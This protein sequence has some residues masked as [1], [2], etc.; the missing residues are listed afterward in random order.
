MARQA[1]C[2]DAIDDETLPGCRRYAIIEHEGVTIGLLG[3]IEDSWLETLSS[4]D[5]RDLQYEDF[6]E[7]ARWWSRRLREDHQCDIVIALTHMRLP[8]DV[9]LGRLG[10]AIGV[11]LVLGG[12]DHFYSTQEALPA[13]SAEAAAA[14]LDD[15]Q[16]APETS[17][18]GP[19]VPGACLVAKSGTD[20]RN[21]TDIRLTVRL[22]APLDEA[23]ET[24]RGGVAA[25]TWEQREVTSALEP[26]AED[27]GLVE[28]LSSSMAA[29][30]GQVLGHIHA[31]LDGRFSSVRGG[32]SN[33]GN[34]VC[35][36]M[37]RTARADCAL[38]NGGTL[39]S[40][41]VHPA[42][43][44]TMA[45]LLKISPYPSEVPTVRVS[46]R[47]I[48]E[49]LENGV[50]KY[51]ES[52]GRF[53][54]VAGIR[55]SFN[56]DA[57][58]MSR[59]DPA[60]VL[61]GHC[62][63]AQAPLNLERRYTLATTD[64]LSL[65]KDGFESI[66]PVT[67]RGKELGSEWVVDLSRAPVLPT[68]IRAHIEV[69]EAINSEQMRFADVG[70]ERWRSRLL[71]LAGKHAR[72]SIVSP[73]PRLSTA[74]ATGALA[75]AG[76]GDHT[77]LAGDSDVGS[78]GA[79]S[80]RG[81]HRFQSSSGEEGGPEPGHEDTAVSGAQAAESF[82][83][84]QQQGDD[85]DDDDGLVSGSTSLRMDADMPASH[86]A[87]PRLSR[88]QSAPTARGPSMLPEL[89]RKAKTAGSGAKALEPLV[90]IAPRL[91]GRIT[92]EAT[93]PS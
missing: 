57:E 71:R 29:A 82:L 89:E 54:Q 24:G 93:A 92:I 85:D 47:A 69:V 74:S 35:E 9:Q 27:L 64:Y 26:S 48:L 76:G 62:P 59:I 33:L 18:S 83:A 87:A 46:G 32:E 23:S 72:G 79:A 25:F 17:G 86:S 10:H 73:G 44:F 53:P 19:S 21:L 49:A 60:K 67:A 43:V 78:A 6:T 36:I 13:A 66:S 75:S 84:K 7:S 88:M 68:L 56:A 58:P 14:G 55:F 28:R 30:A 91:D 51:P 2:A 63:E 12:H 39:R 37:R 4:V 41:L 90:E 11:D 1:V 34:W 22:A 15:I 70:V 3:L 16:P 20:F 45:D 65:G 31:P 81:R 50:S 52:E 61:V 42:G 38:I 80:T 8:R 5:P 40:D 77:P